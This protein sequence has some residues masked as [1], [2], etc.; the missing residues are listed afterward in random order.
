M[1]AHL[2]A[3]GMTGVGMAVGA[4]WLVYAFR[5]VRAGRSFPAL[6]AGSHPGEPRDA[7]FISIVV[8]A[9]DEE[10][11]IEANVRSM[12]SQDYPHFELVVVDDRST[13]QTPAILA[14]LAAEHPGKVRVLTIDRL[15][16]G[17]GGQNHA[18]QRGVLASSGEWLCFTDAD[19]ELHPH[20]LSVAW[21]DRSAHDA[22]LFSIMPRLKAPTLWE[23]MHVPLS[24]YLLLMGF[25]ILN[26]NDPTRPDGYANG[27]FM[28][29]RRAVYDRLGGHAAVRGFVNDDIRLAERAKRRGVRLRVVGNLDLCATRMYETTREAWDG[30]CRN[31]YGGLLEPRKLR[32]SLGAALVLFASP[33]PGFVAA[34]ASGAPL[35]ALAWALPLVISHLA[36][37]QLY[38]SFVLPARWSLLYFPGALFISGV[39]LRAT[40]RAQ[41]R[42]GITWH[43]VHYSHSGDG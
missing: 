1:G 21:Q 29:I 19:C 6:S 12:L 22:E 31:F 41:R 40:V 34:L 17:W 7:P 13:D 11:A 26:V 2:W 39:L 42:A 9:K 43:G 10:H 5:A 18:L 27:A 8:A 24:G 20:T 23:K 4:V 36:V 25:G 33:W 30:W 15:P 38:R 37:A 14:R 16:E 32:R 28:L 35:V 3:V